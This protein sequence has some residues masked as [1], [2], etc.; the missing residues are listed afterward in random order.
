M[1]GKQ[2]VV[3]GLGRFGSSVARTLHSLG[4]EVLAIDS[5]DEA[6]Q[7][8]SESVTQA[9]QADATDEGTL[10][11]L[12]IRNFD[13]AVISI[14]SDIQASIM[15]T[16]IVKE[17]GVK[18]VIA[19]AQNEIHA[20]VL[21]KIGAD[22]VV[23]PERDMGTRVAHNLCSANILDYIELS[24]DYSIM[25]ITALDEWTD[26]SLRQLAMR[27]KYGVN[28]MA[29]KK[30][31]DINISPSADDVIEKGDILVVIG[32]IEELGAIERSR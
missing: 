1:A 27:S 21:Y 12:G 10:K 7:K 5:D 20:K 4:N 15:A 19:K 23:F 30:G 2:Y 25:E 18:Y 24:P 11:S 16:L 29:I 6:I 13:I 14:G 26:K 17:M 9:V 22:K 28:V 31:N 3:I 8:I 32:G